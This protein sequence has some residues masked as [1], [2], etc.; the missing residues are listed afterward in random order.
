LEYEFEVLEPEDDLENAPTPQMLVLNTK[1][2]QLR[3]TIYFMANTA[4]GITGGIAKSAMGKVKL[5]YT[6]ETPSG[7]YTASVSL[8]KIVFTFTDPQGMASN[9]EFN[10][11]KT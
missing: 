9:F 2:N 5:Q 6:A 4:L 11:Q 1:D 10:G 3:V 8:R 7:A